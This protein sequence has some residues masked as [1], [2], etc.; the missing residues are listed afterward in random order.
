VALFTVLT[1][2]TLVCGTGTGV[3]VDVLFNGWIGFIGCNS[4]CIGITTVA[5]TVAVIVKVALAPL[6]KVPIDQTPV[7]L[8]YVPVL[9][10]CY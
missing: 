1:M 7:P 5:F 8:V 10:Q 2:L 9:E 4:S 3:L 6:A